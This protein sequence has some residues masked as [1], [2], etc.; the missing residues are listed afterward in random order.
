MRPWLLLAASAC[1]SGS[2]CTRDAKDVELTGLN[3]STGSTGG[4]G[5]PEQPPPSPSTSALS[6]SP[7]SGVAADGTSFS[8]LTV[9]L[10]DAAGLPVSGVTVRLNASGRA[11]LL[12]QPSVPTDA[13]GETTATLGSTAIETKTVSIAEPALF[14]AVQASV[15][16]VAGAPSAT[17]STISAMPETVA[18]NGAAA[19][20]VLITIR[21]AGGNPL[22]GVTVSFASTGSDH[23]ISQPSS[24]TNA[25]GEAWGSISSSLAET[26]VLSLVQPAELASLTTSVTFAAPNLAVTPET[27]S[28]G[29]TSVSTSTSAFTFTFENSGVIDAI[30]CAAPVLGGAHPDDFVI[31]SDAC[32]TTDLAAGETCAV[33][34][35]ANPSVPST[36]TATLSRSCTFGGSASTT[37]NGIDVNRPHYIFVSKEPY[38]GNLGGMSGADQKCQARAGEG[39]ATMSLGLQW[40]ALLSTQTVNA[41]DRI[42]WR[43]ALFNVLGTRVIDDPRN[44]WGPDGPSG[45]MDQVNVSQYGNAPDQ[46]FVWSGTT[47]E[48]VWKGAGADCAGWTSEAMTEDGWAGDHAYFPAPEWIDSFGSG[49]ED[50]WYSLLCVSQ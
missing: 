11:N 13:N 34:L 3:G 21:D 14:A 39:S 1:W 46:P 26:K 9:T 27:H 42:A 24:L 8:T 12:T 47:A 31:H 7:T 49:C 25:G 22:S 19:A 35:T 38:T 18:A 20:A 37:V 17:E 30:G 15:A 45:G 44:L 32:G 4:T 29:Y 41:K 23:A 6:A 50:P 5:A 28:F 40:K 33:A 48:G 36:R 16:F 10:R 2:A 43:G